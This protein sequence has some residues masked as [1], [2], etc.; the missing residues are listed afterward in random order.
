MGK[1]FKAR[2]G[3]QKYEFQAEV[4]TASASAKVACCLRA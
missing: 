4:R 2:E 1:D 3:A